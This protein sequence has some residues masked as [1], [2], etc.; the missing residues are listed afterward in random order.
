MVQLLRDE[1]KRRGIDNLD[2]LLMSPNY[3]D[4]HDDVA[5]FIVMTQVHHELDTPE[6]L[7]AECKRL[8]KPDGTIAIVDWTD[9]ENGK[10]PPEGRRVPVALIGT[11][12][13]GAGFQQ[14]ETHDVYA[15]HAFVTATA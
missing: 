5:D 13:R 11:Q 6:S 7:L 15:F 4:L 9:E 2:A 3:V 8:L 1:A 10:S 14:I 12:L